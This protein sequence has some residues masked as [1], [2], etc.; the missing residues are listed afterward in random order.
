MA[1]EPEQVLPQQ[2]VAASV[3]VVERH[4]E[5]ALQLEQ[6]VGGDHRRHADHDHPGRD[7]HVPGKDRHTAERHARRARLEDADDELDGRRNGGDLDEAEPE[8]P[9]LRC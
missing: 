8:D 2:R 7:E 5:C 9:D 1:E 6:G 3:G 4:A